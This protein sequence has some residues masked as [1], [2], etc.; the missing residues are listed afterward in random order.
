MQGVFPRLTRTRFIGHKPSHRPASQLCARQT[1]ADMIITQASA[2]SF[3]GAVDPGAEPP[4][5]RDSWCSL[6]HQTTTLCELAAK[7]IAEQCQRLA[8]IEGPEAETFATL[9]QSTL[10]VAERHE[11]LRSVLSSRC[12]ERAARDGDFCSSCRYRTAT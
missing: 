11:V 4:G 3:E 10:T 8:A 5:A 7:A 6:L 2:A 9:L 1:V 12:H